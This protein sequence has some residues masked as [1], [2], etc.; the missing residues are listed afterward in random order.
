VTDQIFNPSI[1]QSHNAKI[2]RLEGLYFLFPCWKA[3]FSPNQAQVEASYFLPFKR[4]IQSLSALQF[5]LTHLQTC[6]FCVYLREV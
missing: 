5:I 1:L 6:D 4:F 3:L 2:N